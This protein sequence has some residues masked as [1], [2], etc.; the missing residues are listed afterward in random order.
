MAG[1][2]P[3]TVVCAVR[4]RTMYRGKSISGCWC[5]RELRRMNPISELGEL[6]ENC[7]NP[8]RRLA[9]DF[10]HLLQQLCCHNLAR[11]AAGLTEKMIS[12]EEFC[13]DLMEVRMNIFSSE[14]F[15]IKIFR[16]RLIVTKLPISLEAKH[17]QKNCLDIQ[18]LGELTDLL[19]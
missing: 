8:G 7:R 17:P 18:K 1:V 2:S 3:S 14:P 13:S 16:N 15:T 11:S 9:W 12:E 10:P 19:I 4:W 5:M 6:F